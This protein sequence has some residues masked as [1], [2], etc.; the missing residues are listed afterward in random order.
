MEPQNQDIVFSIAHTQG[1][2]SELNKQLRD[3]KESL[4]EHLNEFHLAA[5]Q[6]NRKYNFLSSQPA[7]H[8]MMHHVDMFDDLMVGMM[9]RLKKSIADVQEQ[10]EDIKAPL[11][12]KL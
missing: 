5:K 1:D 6:L 4:D 7:F 8:N 9:N 11:T 12:E 10:L 3:T 2:I